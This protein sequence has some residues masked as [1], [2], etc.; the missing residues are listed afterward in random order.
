M[1]GNMKKGYGNTTVGHLFG[2]Y[3]YMGCEYDNIKNLQSK[4]RM[5]HKAK[6]GQP[7]RGSSHPS[8]TFTPNYA[9]FQPGDAYQPSVDQPYRGKDGPNAWKYNNPNKKGFNGTFTEF[10][11][12][13]E[14]G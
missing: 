10:P 12:Y 8:K 14:E 5:E 13:I 6:I 1:T 2:S 11:Q 3:P 9:A 4:E 7:F